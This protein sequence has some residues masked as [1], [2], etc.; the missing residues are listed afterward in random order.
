V[1]RKIVLKDVFFDPNR[2]TLDLTHQKELLD[3]TLE[4]NN[5]MKMRILVIGHTDQM[6]K[7]EF[8]MDLSLRRANAVKAYL[9]QQG[10]D[11]SRIRTEGKGKTELLSEETDAESLR[12]NRRVEIEILEK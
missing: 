5:N 11:S 9:A 1:K 6:G 7:A 4:M 8:N 10:I 12:K 2:S 3:L